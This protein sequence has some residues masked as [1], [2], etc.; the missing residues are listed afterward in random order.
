MRCSSL[1]LLGG[2]HLGAESLWIGLDLLSDLLL[3]L[4]LRHC[5][6]LLRLGEDIGHGG[7]F[8]AATIWS[9]NIL[10]SIILL[11]VRHHLDSR[12]LLVGQIVDVHAVLLQRLAHLRG[13]RLSG[14]L[15][16][17]REGSGAT[18]TGSCG[19][20]QLNRTARSAGNDS[21][22]AKWGA[23]RCREAFGRR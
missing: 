15:W 12:T 7:L 19:L 18:G 8:H 13:D 21:A 9:E 22:F 20:G 16:N 1:L 2:E 23:V 14:D 5:I 10:T 4:L 6:H 11:C 3:L 17:R